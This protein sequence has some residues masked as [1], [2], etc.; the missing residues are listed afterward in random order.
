MRTF[1][2]ILMFSGIALIYF[3]VT[4]GDKSES[5]SESSPPESR[6][7]PNDQPEGP[8]NA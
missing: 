7:S 5:E 3:S 8:L 6:G 1:G 4:A 2:L